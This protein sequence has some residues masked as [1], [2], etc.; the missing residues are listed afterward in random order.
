MVIHFQPGLPRLLL[1]R[2]GLTSG[3]DDIVG[4]GARREKVQL[5]I[6]GFGY[7]PPQ[8]LAFRIVREGCTSKVITELPRA[9][10]WDRRYRMRMPP[11]RDKRV[12]HSITPPRDY[13]FDVILLSRFT[14]FHR[15]AI[16]TETMT[17]ARSIP[18]TL[19]P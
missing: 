7:L 16:V 3:W 17:S 5:I 11:S 15:T 18:F 1:L 10:L 12:S 9:H 2:P 13:V 19:E 4:P 14:T 8:F 6:G